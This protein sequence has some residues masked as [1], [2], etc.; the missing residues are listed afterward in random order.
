M[1]ILTN[2]PK[3]L[4]SSIALILIAGAV[5]C[6]SSGSGSRSPLLGIGN[7]AALAPT[8]T[9]IAPLN[10]ATG[11]PINNTIITA[12]FSEP[13]AFGAGA[14]FTVTTAGSN[15]AGSV[16][17]DATKTRA[18]FTLNAGTSLNPSTTYTAT[19]TGATSLAT[20]LPLDAPFVWTF[21]TGV[22]PDTTLPRVTLTAPV[23]GVPGPTLGVPTNT[24]ITAVFT[25]DLAAASVNSASFTVT[26]AAPGINPAGT[27]TYSVG[28]KTAVF[29]PAAALAANT[30][31]T[32]TLTTAIKDLAGNALA[33]NQAALP[34]ASN[35]VWTFTTAANP[36]L[37][38]NVSVLSSNPAA[39]ARSN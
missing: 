37:P 19:V 36:V 22:A 1:N 31:Y 12:A 5:A 27:V 13:V 29:T 8:V 3:L 32:V 33:G 16:S 7:L 14:S 10:N 25:E 26:T 2:K 24:A 21:K 35:Y 11:V 15:P 20:G 6:G 4:A 9:A 17:L 18:T 30:T 34:A 38:G 28:T 39:S 23:T